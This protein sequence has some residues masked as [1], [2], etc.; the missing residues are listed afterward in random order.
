VVAGVACGVRS[1][2]PVEDNTRIEVEGGEA[3]KVN[4]AAPAAIET[5]GVSATTI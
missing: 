4:G 3:V 1:D 5:A 2:A